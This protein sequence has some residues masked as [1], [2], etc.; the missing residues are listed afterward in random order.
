MLLLGN[1]LLLLTDTVCKVNAQTLSLVKRLLILLP[2]AMEQ[3]PRK[4]LTM[5][6]R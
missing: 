5:L 4:T 3:L 6:M 1:L 2:V